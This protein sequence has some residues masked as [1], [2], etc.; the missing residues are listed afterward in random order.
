MYAIIRSLGEGARAKNITRGLGE[1]R[2]FP[3][4]RDAD[5]RE[6]KH[7]VRHHHVAVRENAETGLM[8]STEHG[9]SP[10]AGSRN[11]AHMY[12]GER[13]AERNEMEDSASLKSSRNA[14]LK[15]A[16]RD[17]RAGKNIGSRDLKAS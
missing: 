2:T 1:M 16:P 12:M 13:A 5:R 11:I 4:M 17:T 14:T 10:T 8:R 9:Q 15:V 6:A 7:S 3:D